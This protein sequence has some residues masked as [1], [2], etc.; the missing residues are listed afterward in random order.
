MDDESFDDLLGRMP[1]EIFNF[2][3]ESCH[4]YRL[5]KNLQEG[6]NASAEIKKFQSKFDKI[7]KELNYEARFMLSPALGQFKEHLQEIVRL[8][9]IKGR[10]QD[11][12]RLILLRSLARAYEATSGKKP[13]K[14]YCK[15]SNV[16]SGPF[17]EFASCVI[18][19]IDGE[20]PHPPTL[21]SAINKALD[22]M[23]KPS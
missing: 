15:G 22:S 1:E 21:K 14:P 4:N 2:V 11:F 5:L 10:K 8:V 17:F 7:E 9:S 19:T 6:P 3:V 23:P 18:E 13:G 16:Y 12:P 20:K